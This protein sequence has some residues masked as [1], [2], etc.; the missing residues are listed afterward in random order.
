M[1]IKG[2]FAA[3]PI[4]TVL[5]AIVLFI[6]PFADM[7]WQFQAIDIALLVLVVL[8]LIIGL[9]HFSVHFGAIDVVAVLLMTLLLMSYIR[10][11][12]GISVFIKME[13]AFL[14]YFFGRVCYKTADKVIN[15]LMIACCL[16]LLINCAVMVS[17]G[18]YQYWGAAR[19]F[20]GLYYFKTDLASAAILSFTLALFWAKNKVLKLIVFFTSA[21]LIVLSNARVYYIALLLV[22]LVYILYRRGASINVRAVLIG[23]AGGFV[24]LAF[25]NWLFSTGIFDQYSYIGIRFDKLSDLFDASNTQGRNVIWAELLN[26]IG[27]SNLTSKLFGIDLVSDQVF[28]NGNTYGSHSLY[29]GLL[30]NVGIIGL[31]LFSLFEGMTLSSLSAV[32]KTGGG[33][34]AFFVA[35]LVTTFLLSGISV[36]TLQYTNTSWIPLFFVGAAVSMCSE[37]NGQQSLGKLQ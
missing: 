20:S 11:G 14:L 6:K 32:Q 15:S 23:L 35:A 17:G 34:Y 5:P 3:K 27:E 7:L 1:K 10:S 8:G 2:G 37:G 30:F 18:G 28:V 25:L 9:T 4:A 13:S 33:G 19:T 24:A 16:V 36:H 12:S 31:L 21:G 29:V 26:R 22:I